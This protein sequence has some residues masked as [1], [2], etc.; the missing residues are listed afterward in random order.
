MRCVGGVQER[1]IPWG[2][3]VKGASE[4]AVRKRWNSM[5]Q[6]MRGWRDMELNQ[7][8]RS[9]VGVGVCVW[10]GV[11]AVRRSSRVQGDP[12]HPVNSLYGSTVGTYP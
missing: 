1:Q 10:V 6:C 4:G 12:W 7:I 8:V 9:S 2:E 5:K 3:L 11:D